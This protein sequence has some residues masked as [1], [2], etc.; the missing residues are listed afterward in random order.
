MCPHCLAVGMAGL[1]LAVPGV[2]YVW[3][4]I[5]DNLKQREQS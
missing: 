2:R 4:S 1:L 3:T 5:R